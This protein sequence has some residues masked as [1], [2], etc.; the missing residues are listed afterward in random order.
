M[1]FP[2]IQSLWAVRQ[3]VYFLPYIVQLLLSLVR[4][5][6]KLNNFSDFN[7]QLLP[8]VRIMILDDTSPKSDILS[9]ILRTQEQRNSEATLLCKK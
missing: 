7:R 2:L 4:S 9:R 8:K 3:P 1:G 6:N 5:K